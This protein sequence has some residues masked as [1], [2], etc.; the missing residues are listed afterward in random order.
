M[1]TVVSQMR[2]SYIIF[3]LPVLLTVGTVIMSVILTAVVIMCDLHF[4]NS[5]FLMLKWYR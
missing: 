3:T 2:E 1:T 5:K 4:A